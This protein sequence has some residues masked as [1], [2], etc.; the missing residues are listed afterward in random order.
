MSQA[1]AR[2]EKDN[3]DLSSELAKAT[4]EIYALRKEL[5]GLKRPR[6]LKPKEDAQPKNVWEC[7]QDDGQWMPYTDELCDEFDKQLYSSDSTA[8]NSTTKQAGSAV[9]CSGG[10][11]CVISSYEGAN[12]RSG[13]ACNSCGTRKRGERWWCK[14]C[15]EDFCHDCKPKSVATLVIKKFRLPHFHTTSTFDYEM[16]RATP[17]DKRVTALGGNGCQFEQYNCSTKKTRKVRAVPQPNRNASHSPDDDPARQ[18]QSL[19]MNQNKNF[20]IGDVF[21]YRTPAP[22]MLGVPTKTRLHTPKAVTYHEQPL[23]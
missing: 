5:E 3:K 13:W 12:Y 7:L 20:W 19:I 11:T 2:L 16:R 22:W 21:C 10:H 23:L 18:S 4:T 1:N 14:E 9:A 15:S 8:A 6:S 17:T